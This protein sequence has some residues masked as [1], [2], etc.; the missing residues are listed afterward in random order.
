MTEQ[1]LKDL[2]KKYPAGEQRRE[3][4]NWQWQMNGIDPQYV[5]DI[6]REIESEE[7]A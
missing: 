1:E 4:A 7:T 6:M 3:M 2:L 5:W